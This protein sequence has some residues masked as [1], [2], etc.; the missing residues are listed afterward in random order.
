[1]SYIARL[2]ADL[3]RRQIPFIHLTA[4]H[5]QAIEAERRFQ[6]AVELPLGMDDKYKAMFFDAR[7]Y[8]ASCPHVAVLILEDKAN[9]NQAALA[10]MMQV[11]APHQ[12]GEVEPLVIEVLS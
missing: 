7:I 8:G 10:E 12:S 11:P 1:M 6:A 5:R 9:M 4:T 3:F 2:E